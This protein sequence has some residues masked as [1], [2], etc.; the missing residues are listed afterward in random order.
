MNYDASIAEIDRIIN[1]LAETINENWREDVL[2]VIEQDIQSVIGN[3]YKANDSGSY[4]R[5][6][7][8]FFSVKREIKG[9]T[10]DGKFSELAT[11]LKMIRRDLEQRKRLAAQKGEDVETVKEQMLQQQSTFRFQIYLAILVMVSSW[12]WLVPPLFNFGSLNWQGGAQ[13]VFVVLWLGVYSKFNI[14]NTT[15]E[16][17]ISAMVNLGIALL[18]TYLSYKFGWL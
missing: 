5:W 3:I 7:D 2:P 14:K 13:V 9:W 1:Y 17:V 8:Q 18:A 4:A 16:A 6:L 11:F 12:I 10:T 15:K